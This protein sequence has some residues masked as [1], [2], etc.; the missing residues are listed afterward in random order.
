MHS[1]QNAYQI[2]LSKDIIS[3]QNIKGSP[4]MLVH[5]VVLS[6]HEVV[7]AISSHTALWSWTARN[8]LWHCLGGGINFPEV[9]QSINR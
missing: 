4:N 2:Q 3:N 8:M 7:P 6:V 9:V 5:A 1:M